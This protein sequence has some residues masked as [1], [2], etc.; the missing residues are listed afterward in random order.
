VLLQ[1]NVYLVSIKY[2]CNAYFFNALVHVI[3][4]AVSG[5]Y[6]YTIWSFKPEYSNSI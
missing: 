1:L 5:Q 2:T 6:W 3:Y 4:S